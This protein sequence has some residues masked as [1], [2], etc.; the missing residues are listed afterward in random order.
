[1]NSTKLF[2]IR[3]TI[4][5]TIINFYSSCSFSETSNQMKTSLNNLEKYEYETNEVKEEKETNYSNE[6]INS[7]NKPKIKRIAAFSLNNIPKLKK[8]LH[9]DNNTSTNLTKQIPFKN[10]N[11]EILRRIRIPQDGSCLFNSVFGYKEGISSDEKTIRKRL[12][13]LLMS[14]FIHIKDFLKEEILSNM[15]F[16]DRI[17]HLQLLYNFFSKTDFLESSTDETTQLNYQ[18]FCA[19]LQENIEKVKLNS[20]NHNS[21]KL[22][23]I[24]IDLNNDLVSNFGELTINELSFNDTFLIK[25][26]ECICDY[27]LE[28]KNR[29]W[30]SDSIIKSLNIAIDKHIIVHSRNSKNINQTTKFLH[31]NIIDE[32]DENAIH[33]EKIGHHFNLLEPNTI[34]DLTN[35]DE[36]DDK[37]SLLFTNTS[38]EEDDD[39]YNT[40]SMS[41]DSIKEITTIL[42]KS[43][44]TFCKAY[45][46]QCNKKFIEIIKDL[47]IIHEKYIMINEVDNFFKD[48]KETK[49][50]VTCENSTILEKIENNIREFEY[51]YQSSLHVFSLELA[52]FEKI[53]DILNHILIVHKEFDSYIKSQKSETLKPDIESS[54]LLLMNKLD[55]IENLIM[56]ISKRY[57]FSE[58]KET[59]ENTEHLLIKIKFL[60][61]MQLDRFF[62]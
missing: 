37:Y 50:Y 7:P 18:G 16:I 38:E 55:E 21:K 46:R 6:E 11:N 12:K 60:L 51:I 13:E 24:L 52:F 5:S 41:K 17:E 22:K 4:L 54:S 56:D 35:D 30:G 3:L 1:M 43:D 26:I 44:S 53:K 27:N 47:C 59:I 62:S 58:K 42:D 8:K 29:Y 57:H 32:T 14:K 39:N 34:I 2:F 19:I 9:Q 61:E 33:I 25:F 36:D 15:K 10:F 49:N 40:D 23:S 48:F 28:M 45:V 31:P 20:T